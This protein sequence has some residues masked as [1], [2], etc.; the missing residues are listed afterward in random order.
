MQRLYMFKTVQKVSENGQFYITP[1]TQF[2]KNQYFNFVVSFL[3]I[4]HY[5]LINP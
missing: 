1:K 4:R 2:A 3:G 5:H